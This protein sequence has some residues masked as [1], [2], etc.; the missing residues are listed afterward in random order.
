MKNLLKYVSL[1]VFASLVAC[2]GGS[3]SNL[4]Q[5]K[6]A[7]KEKQKE[8]EKLNA[9]IKVLEKEIT[10][11]DPNF[12]SQKDN[13]VLV[14]T[15]KLAP[16]NFVSYVEVQGTVE[17]DKNVVLSAETNGIIRRVLV[18]EGQYVA[19]GQ[20]LVAQDAMVIE[21]GI[22]EV[23]KSLELA[24]VVYKR[25][26]K[27]WEQ[28][29]GTEIQYLEAKNNKERLERQLATLQAQKG[30]GA[31]TAP[32][33]GIVDEIIARQGQNAGPGTP[34]LRLVS[35]QRINVVADVSEAYLGKVKRGDVVKVLFPS[36]EIEQEAPVT[37]IGQTID[38]DN[39]TFRIEVALNN[40]NNLLKP[41]L[42]AQVRIRKDE[43]ANAVVVPTNLIQRDK[44]GDF[45]FVV[46]D[47]DKKD[48]K[49]AKKIRIQR[50]ETYDN[51]TLV[52]KGLQ[53]DEVLIREG[54]R[55]VVDGSSI[56]VVKKEASA[57]IA[58]R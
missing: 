56:K 9:E 15:Q 18:E 14:S 25:Q 53:G 22:A 49:L 32:F 58:T 45:I 5:K 51:Q 50:G 27:L 12:V 35:A 20:L 41:D 29:I 13:A 36:L 8:V 26:S 6:Q 24:E 46:G 55:D 21:M 11:L 43:Q 39:R 19:A 40:P 57:K 52:I 42:L 37:L 30:Q 1:I 48:K 44:I 7:L 23:Q 2:G 16:K 38:P 33:S 31:T 54:F 28:E 34:L 17:S 47:S 3:E 4:D 10:Q